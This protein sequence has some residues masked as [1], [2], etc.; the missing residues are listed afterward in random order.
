MDQTTRFNYLVNCFKAGTAT[1]AELEELRH[2][3][4]KPDDKDSS[5]IDQSLKDLWTSVANSPALLPDETS[6]RILDSIISPA[7]ITSIPWQKNKRQ[8]LYLGLTA[9]AAVL[10]FIFSGNWIFLAKPEP[11][12]AGT[13][14]VT[15]KS[16]L[17]IVPGTTKAELILGDGSTVS[18]DS[19]QNG[20]IVSQ[21]NVSVKNIN[22]RIVYTSGTGPAEGKPLSYNTLRTPKGGFYQLTLSDGTKLWLNAASS[23]RYPVAFNDKERNVELNGEAYFEV[24][25]DATRPFHVLV[26]GMNIEVLGTHFNVMAYDNEKS[27]KTTLLEGSV[28]I[29]DGESSAMLRPGQQARLEPG[30]RMEVLS[31]VNT[32]D[33]IAWKNGF[34][35][36]DRAGLDVLMR[37]IE[38]WYDVD[39]VFE[40]AIQE[41][42]FGGKISRSKNIQD[43]LKILELSKVGFRIDDKKIIVSN[44]S[45]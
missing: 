8:V 41:R 29:Q 14:V 15:K 9:A 31:N 30:N 42:A 13:A 6:K 11:K 32:D 19:T 39:V 27:I 21:E 20:D 23:L 24:A 16:A 5:D 17:Q 33:V 44:K 26:N 28:K 3:L 45:R 38:R 18:L 2:L 22:G 37:Q 7:K 36:F 10:I 40:G 34:F 4:H 25:K 1:Q 12:I 35:Q 43:V